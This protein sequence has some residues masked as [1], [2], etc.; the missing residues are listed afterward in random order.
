MALRGSFILQTCLKKVVFVA[1]MAFIASSGGS[2]S[3][4]QESSQTSLSNH[5]NISATTDTIV[6][7]FEATVMNFLGLSDDEET[8]DNASDSASQ[9]DFS[10]TTDNATSATD[11]TDNVPEDT[12]SAPSGDIAEDAPPYQPEDFTQSASL[13]LLNKISTNISRVTLI[14]DT[15][16]TLDN[17]TITLHSCWRAPIDQLPESKALLKIVEQLPGEDERTVFSG[18]MFASSPS[19]SVLEHPVYD[20]RL[21]ECSP[22]Q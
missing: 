14:K 20:A 21:L 7:E 5:T 17:L 22:L 16:F 10:D 6:P 2:L 19:L 1:L 11:E 13:Q 8:S 9:D 12:N 18:W 15:P 3:F 4:A